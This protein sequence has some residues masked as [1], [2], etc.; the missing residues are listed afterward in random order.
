M[1]HKP[2]MWMRILLADMSVV[3]Q[4]YGIHKSSICL[5]PKTSS[6][7][8]LNAEPVNIEVTGYVMSII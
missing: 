5:F 6:I 7:E 1:K 3:M 4:K 8:S 2:F